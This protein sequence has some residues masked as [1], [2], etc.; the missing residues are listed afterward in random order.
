MNEYDAWD[1]YFL[2]LAREVATNSKCLSRKIGAVIVKDKAVVST[3]Y[4]GPAR[5]TTH[6]DKRNA[7]FYTSIDENRDYEPDTANEIVV[8]FRH[9]PRQTLGYSSGKGLHLC[10]AGHAE[11]NAIVQAARNGISTKDTIM[12]A[13]CLLPCKDCCIEIINSGIKKIV[14]LDSRPDYDRY[15][16]VLLNEAGIEI[17]Q[18]KQEEL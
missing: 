14:C 7:I 9:C 17:V 1:L 6:C 5:G 16:R 15:S 12:Y 13:Y 4:N 18:I 3:G 10:Q 8:Y 2:R 11:R